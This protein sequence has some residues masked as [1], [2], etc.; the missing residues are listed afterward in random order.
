MLV[1]A[2]G[3]SRFAVG[4]YE[5]APLASRLTDCWTSPS[6]ADWSPRISTALSES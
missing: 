1:M 2:V 4:G 6:L 3:N 5:V